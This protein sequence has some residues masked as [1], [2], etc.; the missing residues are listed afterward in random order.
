[1]KKKNKKKTNKKKRVNRKK[2]KIESFNKVYSLLL[3]FII[4]LAG[5]LF[6][7]VKTIP[8]GASSEIKHPFEIS[9]LNIKIDNSNLYKA[10]LSKK[11]NQ[12]LIISKKLE[13]ILEKEKLVIISQITET[14]NTETN[15]IIKKIIIKDQPTKDKK[16]IIAR[17]S[18]ATNN[19][20]K[21][22]TKNIEVN[23]IIKKII[24]KDQPTE[25]K[26]VIIA[27]TSDATN[28]LD[29]TGTK[30]E[31]EII[32]DFT[33]D[34]E[35][36]TSKIA[37]DTT[38]K[39]I[40]I[41]GEKALI[42]GSLDK[43]ITYMQILQNPND[44][45]LNLKYA[46]QQEKAGN[47]K[48]TISTLERLNML[49]PD[50]IEI[51]LYLL[52]VLVQADSPNKALTLIEEIKEKDLTASDLETVN[53]IKEELKSGQE[54]K[55]WNFYANFS[56]GAIQN[57]NV[58]SVSKTRL[59]DSS[60]S[61]TG[62]NTAKFDRTYTG[63]LGLTAT[64]LLGK[65]SSL[66]I[67]VSGTGSNQEH[68]RTDDFTDYGM[69]LSLD[70]SLGNQSLSPYLILT[71]QDPKTDA[72]NFSLMY[73]IGGYFQVGDR[74]SFSYGYNYTDSKADHNL[75]DSTADETNAIGHGYSLGHD[76]A[77]NSI[78]STSTSIGYSDSDAKDDTNDYETYDLVLSLNLA[79]PFAD[80]SIGDAL[81][82]NDYKKKDTSIN[83]NILRSD[84]TN[85]FDIMLTKPLGD[86][87]PR[88]DPNRSFF[89]NLSYEK[90]ISESNIKNY[91]YLS[92]SYSISFSKTVHLNK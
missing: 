40:E 5:L 27:R 43:N 73:G 11:I 36:E 35:E 92:N 38:S 1:M 33:E 82:L 41:E 34:K 84:L 52:S 67:N 28:N 55:L 47:H 48:Q 89:I 51:K 39:V 71:K 65:A 30:I 46:R 4:L 63:S 56:T 61:V 72:D 91:D 20:D 23:K 75:S 2:E 58:N 80:I 24:I 81:S 54:P 53:E 60:D 79:F 69:T 8:V 64:R 12:D 45:D 57:N 83:S 74:N 90:V 10:F 42:S 31:D 25:D 68:D 15:K 22:G 13:P 26:K 3:I 18:D 77:V 6:E 29:K 17:A 21:T 14:K 66:I 76:F 78:F 62:F 32:K 87:F 9:E 44:L 70:T 19:L 49:Y 37:A 16:I 7:T 86:F 59:Q 88:I 85:T 50:N